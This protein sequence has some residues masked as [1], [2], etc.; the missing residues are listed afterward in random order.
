MKTT[1]TFA[2]A[3]AALAMGIAVTGT[4]FADETTVGQKVDDATLVAK[5]KAE[6]LK[7]PDVSGLAVNVDATNGVVTLS[8]NAKTDVE[9]TKAQEIAQRAGGVAKVDNKIVI[10]PEAK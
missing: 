7:S 4:T 3:L 1:K 5:I 8:G 2:A 6:L 10:K 9:R